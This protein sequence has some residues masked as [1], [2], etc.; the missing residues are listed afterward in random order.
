MAKSKSKSTSKSVDGIERKILFFRVCNG[1][2]ESGKPI[3]FDPRPAFMDIM[4]HPYDKRAYPLREGSFLNIQCEKTDVIPLRVSIVNIR[5]NDLPSVEHD[6]DIGPLDI[7]EGD[8]IAERTHVVLF[9]NNIV[10]VENNYRGPRIGRLADYMKEFSMGI[11]TDKFHFE[12]LLRNDMYE[13]FLKL[14][15]LKLLEFKIRSSF[16]DVV[17]EADES[18]G[19]CFDAA[20]RAGEPDIVQVTMRK[21][22]RSDSLCQKL[23]DAV[24]FVI[25]N[26]RVHQEAQKLVARG[27][28]TETGESEKIDLLEDKLIVVKTVAKQMARG[29]LISSD[30]MYQA[31]E[32]AYAEVKDELLKASGI[33]T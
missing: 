31:I 16:I 20:K 28:N 27:L 25:R 8:G 7:P 26:P 1:L 19:A 22:K 14:G 15:E 30:S 12:P 11:D 9:A 13:R 10:G 33:F 3:A 23:K 5:H 2:D 4:R 32:T 18:L 24:K 21:E 29:R 17:K 6:G